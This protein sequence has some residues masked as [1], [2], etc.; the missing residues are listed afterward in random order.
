MSLL[1]PST[2]QICF[3]LEV[4]TPFW[5]IC[6]TIKVQGT[7]VQ[8]GS[9]QSC[10]VRPDRVMF[11]GPTQPV[12]FVSG[13]A[14]ERKIPKTMHFLFSFACTTGP[15]LPVQ[16]IHGRLGP[17]HEHST[18]ICL[19]S[20]QYAQRHMG[21]INLVRLKTNGGKGFA[22]KQVCCHRLGSEL[23]RERL[24]E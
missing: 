9:S 5:A 11:G 10:P 21:Q 14:E 8:V 12:G 15:V 16:R 19:S 4:P 2:G 13:S 23:V 6:L 24:G 7:A 17:G 3:L 22:V 1:P 20:A 18:S